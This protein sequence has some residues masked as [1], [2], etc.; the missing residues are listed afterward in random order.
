M[1]TAA[2]TPRPL[3]DDRNARRSATRNRPHLLNSTWSRRKAGTQLP[4]VAALAETTTF[5][6][7]NRAV[8]PRRS[9][10]GAAGT[11]F[12]SRQQDLDHFEEFAD[13]DRLRHEP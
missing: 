8:G 6:S 1:A 12:R 9:T 7:A 3:R 13:R 10:L 4:W 11:H 5:I 2:R